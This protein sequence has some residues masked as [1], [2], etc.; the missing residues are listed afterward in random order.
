MLT[1]IINEELGKF[2][3]EKDVE[4]V[5]KGTEEVDADEYADT[6]EKHIDYAK[7]LKVEEARLVKRL[8]KIREARQR[9]VRKIAAKVSK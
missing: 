7:A 2:G 1:A 6:L 4:K 8:G 3:A 5:A 9:I